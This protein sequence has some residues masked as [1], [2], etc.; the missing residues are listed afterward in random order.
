MTPQEHIPP[1]LKAKLKANAKATKQPQTAEQARAKKKSNRRQHEQRSTPE[2]KREERMKA[3][4]VGVECDEGMNGAPFAFPD[5]PLEENGNSK[6][7]KMDRKEHL[8]TEATF[9]THER[10]RARERC[11]GHLHKDTAVASVPEVFGEHACPLTISVKDL[12]SKGIVIE[13]ALAKECGKFIDGRHGKRNEHQLR[14][15]NLSKAE[16]GQDHQHVCSSVV[17]LACLLQKR[18]LGGNAR[19]DKKCLGC[20][21][22][23]GERAH[24]QGC[25]VRAAPHKNESVKGNKQLE[26]TNGQT[27]TVTKLKAGLLTKCGHDHLIQR[28]RAVERKHNKTK[29]N[30]K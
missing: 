24:D 13:V 5:T 15:A 29:M 8:K 26:G 6:E 4:H 16:G 12:N 14:V 17:R 9:K 7:I 23:V 20:M 1:W 28:M 21:W 30:Q 3:E 10:N 25:F 11:P 22:D 18:I 2:R 27:R 19:K